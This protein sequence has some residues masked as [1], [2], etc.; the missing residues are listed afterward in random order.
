M[1][2]TDWSV[3]SSEASDDRN[4]LLKLRA[5]HIAGFLSLV[6]LL[7][8]GCGGGGGGGGG[9]ASPS[10]PPSGNV[11]FPADNATGVPVG[12]PIRV[13]FDRD[14]DPSTL[15]LS[16]VSIQSGGVPVTGSLKYG[17]LYEVTVSSGVRDA[18]GNP[19]GPYSWRF[20]TEA[21]PT[22]T[23]EGILFLDNNAGVSYDPA[24]RTVT[25]D[26]NARYP[27][28][29]ILVKAVQPSSDNSAT[30]IAEV[31]TYAAA[32]GAFRFQGLIPGK[33][34]IV[35]EK[36][37]PSG[38]RILGVAR[39]YLNPVVLEIPMHDVTPDP[40]DPA[41]N[42]VRLD[43]YCLGCHPPAGGTLHPHPSGVVPKKANP[44]TGSMDVYGRVT[45]DSCHTV[46]YPTGFQHYTLGSG[47]AWCNLCHNSG[48]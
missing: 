45:C 12:T 34:M 47:G 3:E 10:P 32:S 21:A 2:S 1:L 35:A 41:D 5:G 27:L 16:T 42:V 28:S 46:H 25:L 18:S 24:T 40:A 26:M 29:G 31:D 14:M 38:V 15:T 8:S 7:A 22:T 17:T 19:F 37:F 13:T 6:L 33:Q 9:P 30:V 44:P 20:T 4:P 39:T 43:A 23:V 11:P 36:V 48:P